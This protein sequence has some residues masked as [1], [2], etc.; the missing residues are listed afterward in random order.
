MYTAGIIAE[1]NPFHLGHAYHLRRTREMGATH[2]VA[3]LGGDFTQ[4]GDIALLSKRLRAEA[5]VRCGADLVLELPSL[6]SMST[7]GNFALGGVSALK[8]LGVVDALSFGSECGEVEPLQTAAAAAADPGLKPA[9]DRFL[10]QGMTFA[11]ARQAAVAEGCGEK[12]AGLLASPNNTLGI[13]YISAAGRL[14]A[15]FRFLTVRRQ[16]AAHDALEAHSLPSAAAVRAKIEAG[17]DPSS[18]LPPQSAALLMEAVRTGET[19]SLSRLESSILCKLKLMDK[20]DFSRLPDRSEGIENRLHAAV[21]EAATLDGLCAAVKTKRYPMARVRRLI[22]S[23]FLGFDD[24]FWL[25]EVPYLRVLALN[26]RGQEILRAAKGKAEKP[27]L[28]SVADGMRLGGEAAAVLSYEIKTA[29][30]FNMATAAKRCEKNAY[31]TPIFN[32]MEETS[33]E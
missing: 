11:A 9:L 25:R 6:W 23:A 21:R 24:R 12:T 13:E 15:D 16:G 33:W 1:Y 26:R 5:A 18:A 30:L 3:L 31:T 8:S 20:A 22:L 10:A 19:A 4:R 2:I 17:L 29:D 28:F 14:S 32:S 27:I 7:A